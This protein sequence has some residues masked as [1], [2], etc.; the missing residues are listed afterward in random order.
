V[1]AQFA[2]EGKAFWADYFTQGCLLYS[3]SVADFDH[4]FAEQVLLHPGAPPNHSEPNKMIRTVGCVGDSIWIVCIHRADDL[5]STW[6]LEWGWDD[7]GVCRVALGDGLLQEG[8]VAGVITRLPRPRGGWCALP[9]CL[10]CWC[11]VG[12]PVAKACSRLPYHFSRSPVI[13]LR[14]D[15]FQ[16]RQ[17]VPSKKRVKVGRASSS[18]TLELAGRHQLFHYHIISFDLC[19]LYLPNL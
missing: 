11:A 3:G 2:F 9:Q 4:V 18:I 8:Q 12:T 7:R 15:F 13:L 6:T 1:G 17:H 10:V 14:Y 16:A 19:V 5:L